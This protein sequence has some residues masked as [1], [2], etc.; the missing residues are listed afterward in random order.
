MHEWIHD[1]AAVLSPKFHRASL[2]ILA[3]CLL[4]SPI[5]LWACLRRVLN[6]HSEQV[7]RPIPSPMPLA[8]FR[9]PCFFPSHVSHLPTHPTQ[10]Q[11]HMRHRH[12]DHHSPHKLDQYER[13]WRIQPLCSKGKDV[14]FSLS[15]LPPRS[16]FQSPKCAAFIPTT[17]ML[18]HHF[19]QPN[20]TMM[21]LMT[22][23]V[24]A[25]T[26]SHP[27]ALYPFPHTYTTLLFPHPLSERS[28]RRSWYCDG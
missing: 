20:H 17:S 1:D 19:S 28:W 16:H 12:H 10:T 3:N 6:C 18:N 13:H 2:S 9:P 23:L 8:C 5:H 15:S 21:E 7:S 11:T 22:G 27:R 14:S 24:P 26:S 25:A 4:Y